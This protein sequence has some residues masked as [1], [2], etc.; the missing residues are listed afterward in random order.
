MGP[1]LFVSAG[2]REGVEHR[3][4]CHAVVSDCLSRHDSSVVGNT[5]EGGTTITFQ[6][7]TD[8]ASSVWAPEEPE[9]DT[10]ACR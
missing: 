2:I 4:R 8:I 6:S 7:I 9:A 10:Y 5:A 1:E 3:P